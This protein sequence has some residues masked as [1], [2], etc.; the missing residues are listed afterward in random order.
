MAYAAE[1]LDEDLGLRAM[2]SVL[3]RAKIGAYTDNTFW[4]PRD[5]DLTEGG[6]FVATRERLSPG[7]VVIVHLRLGASKDVVE[8]IASVCRQRPGSSG[9]PGLALQFLDVQPRAMDRIRR[10]VAMVRDP[11]PLAG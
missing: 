11:M 1:D 10:F 8:V 4:A 6:V 2:A 3:I 7:T 9:A 5:G